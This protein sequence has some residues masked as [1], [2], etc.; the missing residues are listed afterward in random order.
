MTTR[1]ASLAAA[2]MV[3]VMMIGPTLACS[4]SDI[5]ITQADLNDNHAFQHAIVVGELVN[6]CGD[7]AKVE[8][9]AVIRD[10]DGRVLGAQDWWAAELGAIAPHSKYGFTVGVE[11]Q[12]DRPAVKWEVLVIRVETGE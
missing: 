4:T 7:A 11:R 12:F 9:H 1:L 8:L 3:D 6:N 5:V 2:F 10:S